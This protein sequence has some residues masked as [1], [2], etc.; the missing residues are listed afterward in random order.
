MDNKILDEIVKQMER[1][2]KLSPFTLTVT[3]DHSTENIETHIGDQ[4]ADDE[5]M[6]MLLETYMKTAK[7]AGINHECGEPKCK[8]KEKT[9]RIVTSIDRILGSYD[10]NDEYKPSKVKEDKENDNEQM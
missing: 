7:E 10:E 9:R 5:A 2:K 4:L 3:L 6:S 1:A 8:L